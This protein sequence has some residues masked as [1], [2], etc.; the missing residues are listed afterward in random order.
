MPGTPLDTASMVR[1]AAQELFSGAV[2]ALGPGIPCCLP[3]ELLAT[4]AYGFS[5]TVAP[6]V[7]KV[8][9]KTLGQWTLEATPCPCCP[10]EP[11][12]A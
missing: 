10:V 12:P 11:G 8:R 2:V 7:L 1:R 4:A 9:V 6:W 3:K 5:P